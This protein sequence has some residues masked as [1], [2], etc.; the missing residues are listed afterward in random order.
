MAS[1]KERQIDTSKAKV[2]RVGFRQGDIRHSLADISL[3]KEFL[4]Y[5]PSHDLF[6][7]IGELIRSTVPVK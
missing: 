7:G 6:S 5:N 2:M 3:A 1:L 4:G